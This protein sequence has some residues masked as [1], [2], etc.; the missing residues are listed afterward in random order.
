MGFFR[1]VERGFAWGV[2]RELAHDAVRSNRTTAA[3][4]KTQ[5]VWQARNAELT[6]GYVT[7]RTVLA[8]VGDQIR[9][10]DTSRGATVVVEGTIAQ[11]C[12]GGLVKVRL[13]LAKGG[14][15]VK[16]AK[17]AQLEV[18]P[19]PADW[20]AP[21]PEAKSVLLYKSPEWFARAPTRKPRP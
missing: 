13:P 6:L 11:L 7:D 5:A 14:Y 18:L 4:R 10:G 1:T 19:R 12:W 21:L 2:G 17:P 16:V 3:Q 20:A 9:F 15:T 8:Y